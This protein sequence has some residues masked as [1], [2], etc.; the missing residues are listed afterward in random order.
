[1]KGGPAQKGARKREVFPALKGNPHHVTADL[2]GTNTE[3]DT[4]DF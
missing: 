4:G 1:V 3:G 2:D